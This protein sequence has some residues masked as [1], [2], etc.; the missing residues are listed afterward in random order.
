MATIRSLDHTKFVCAHPAPPWLVDVLSS[1][2]SS[3]SS[4]LAGIQHRN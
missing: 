4:S 1:F 3:F 2:S